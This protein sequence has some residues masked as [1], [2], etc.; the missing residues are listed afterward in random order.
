MKHLNDSLEY[1]Q[2][3]YQK[4]GVDIFQAM[5]Q[6]Q[7][8]SISIHCWQGDDVTGFEDRNRVLSG[9]I[10]VT[11]SYPGKAR[12]I[13]ELRDDLEMVLK[14][15][16]GT[17]RLNLHAIYLDSD[18][19]IDRKD[20]QPCHFESWVEWGKRYDLQGLDFNPTLFSHPLS[21]EGFT[22]SHPNNEIRKYWIEH[23]KASRRIGVYFAQE[24]NSLTVTNIWI[25][26]G[27]KDTPYDRYIYRNYL[28]QSLD[29]I[30]K[31]NLHSPNHYDCVESKLFGIG[32]ESY[33]VGSHEF[34]MGYAV[35]KQIA[36][37]LD[38]GHFHPTETITDKLTA[39]S[40]FIPHILLHVSRP[41]RWDSDHVVLFNDE[42]KDTMSQLSRTNL[43]SKI[44]LGLDY[45]DA[46]INRVSAWI[47]GLRNVQKAILYSLLEPTDL[48]K[49][50]ELEQ[51]YT[52]KL[53][54]LE[55][56]KTFPF[57]IVWEHY[58]TQQGVSGN[59]EWI[60]DIEQ[61]EQNIL[62]KRDK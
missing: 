25:P 2:S 27:M 34:Y 42:L 13:N 29:E 17:K 60:K 58:C 54:Y 11:G 51:N 55:E 59:I 21:D 12:N 26:D 62:S 7:K 15:V 30:L 3:C 18:K 47:I 46:S 61:Y 57:S 31:E 4:F 20:I 44:S 33:T 6:A 23:C 14:H 39:I 28:Q 38:A 37:C 40:P 48:L 49:K 52:Q 41:V 56:L 43:W 36:L 9:G 8:I 19:I 35:K 53:A 1:A 10:Q 32:S 22:L 5:E 50:M 24:F 45:F 16:P